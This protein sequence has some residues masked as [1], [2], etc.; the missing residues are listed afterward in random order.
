MSQ[1][2]SALKT[3]VTATIA[4][5]QATLAATMTSTVLSGTIQNGITSATQIQS[6]IS[7]YSSTLL[8]ARSAAMFGAAAEEDSLLAIEGAAMAAAANIRMQSHLGYTEESLTDAYII[9]DNQQNYVGQQINATAS[10][11]AF[12]AQENSRG[13]FD[14]DTRAMSTAITAIVPGAMSVNTVA[15]LAETVRASTAASSMVAAL[16][17]VSALRNLTGVTTDN[18]NW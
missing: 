5:A 7:T 1:S 6:S 15:I 13:V 3:S 14:S 16:S 11:T 9:S 12:I 18:A 10:M 4:Q 2:A 8:A 17:P